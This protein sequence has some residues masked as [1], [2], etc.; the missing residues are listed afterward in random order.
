MRA[1]LSLLLVAAVATAAP[2][3]HKP[4]AV[5]L[6]VD[7]SGSMQGPKLEA[8]KKAMHA[9]VDQLG[10]DDQI[11]IITFDSD[12]AVLV[13]LSK[14]NKSLGKRIDSLQAGGGTNAYPALK[15]AFDALT[16]LKLAHRH[17]LLFTDGEFP[18]DGIPELMT[19]IRSDGIT[20]SAIGV[21]GADRTLLT[22][23]AD[24][25]DGR[26]YMVD[27]VGTLPKVFATEVDRAMR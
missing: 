22:M 10:A 9:V 20:A 16:P 14:P 12:A 8:V 23:I 25:G 18:T 2:A 6:L 19:E 24:G 27:D 5:V 4:G 17:I 13:P 1:A 15:E 3:K 11:E 21:Q 7:R 26:L